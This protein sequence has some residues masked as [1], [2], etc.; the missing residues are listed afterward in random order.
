MIANDAGAPSAGIEIRIAG[1]DHR[2]VADEKGELIF[3]DLAAGEIELIVGQTR[4]VVTLGK[5]D[6]FVEIVLQR[7]TTVVDGVTIR[8]NGGALDQTDAPV[9]RMLTERETNLLSSA[10]IADPLRAAQ[11]LAA[12]RAMTI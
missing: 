9:E 2:A 12:C 11:G 6:N 8:A 1:T 3:T 5:A 4:Q 7:A 10:T